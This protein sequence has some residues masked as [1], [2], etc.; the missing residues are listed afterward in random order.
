M[1]QSSSE[2]SLN[3]YSRANIL[4]GDL[5]NLY[6]SMW[7]LQMTTLPTDSFAEFLQGKGDD[8]SRAFVSAC[9]AI[10]ARSSSHSEIVTKVGPSLTL[11]D[12]DEAG[13][14]TPGGFSEWG[15]RRHGACVTLGSKAIEEARELVQNQPTFRSLKVMLAAIL[16]SSSLDTDRRAS[17]GITLL[18]V[19][20]YR[21]LQNDLTASDEDKRL[22]RESVGGALLARD[23]YFSLNYAEPLVFTPHEAAGIMLAHSGDFDVPCFG[24]PDCA[25][26]SGLVIFD[27]TLMMRAFWKEQFW[28]LYNLATLLD[29]PM[30]A[31]MVTAIRAANASIDL[32]S[33]ELKVRYEQLRLVQEADVFVLHNW[34]GSWRPSSPKTHAL[35]L[36]NELIGGFGHVDMLVYARLQLE[37]DAG[38][39]PLDDLSVTMLLIDARE[40]ARAV[41]KLIA[42]GAANWLATPRKHA[43][44]SSGF[45]SQLASVPGWVDLALGRFGEPDG[46]L[47]KEAELSAADVELLV[48]ALRIGAYSQASIVTPLRELEAGL[49]MLRKEE[50]EQMVKVAE[51]LNLGDFWIGLDGGLPDL[52]M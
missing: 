41:I 36:V 47:S 19:D 48:R 34:S 45:F 46:P 27:E 23:C 40:R 37:L 3:S 17:R 4:K 8:A 44:F 13:Q 24:V 12:D 25:A 38:R 9:I 43:T 35:L 7:P 1:G 51:G 31:A 29:G 52:A 50:L 39:L 15:M 6:S 18:A 11:V 22:A 33:A 30:N 42:R 21:R 5:I 10:G 20:A 49:E 32:L 14:F 2:A 28:T 26:Y 16:L